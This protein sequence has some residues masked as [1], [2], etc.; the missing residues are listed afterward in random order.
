M[1]EVFLYIISFYWGSRSVERIEMPDLETCIES[2]E[3]SQAHIS[4]G[5]ENEAGV[6]LFCAGPDRWRTWNNE[7]KLVETE[8]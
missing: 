8:D 4:P 2:I 3:T 6:V 7:W 5:D 1:N